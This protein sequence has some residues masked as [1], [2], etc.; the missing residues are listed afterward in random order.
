MGRSLKNISERVHIQHN[1]EFWVCALSYIIFWKFPKK[2]QN[3]FSKSTAGRTLLILSDY[4]FKIS[5][6][7]FNPL[8]PGGKKVYFSK[9]VS[10]S[11]TKIPG[12]FKHVCLFVATSITE[13]HWVLRNTTGWVFQWL[14]LP[15]HVTSTA[16]FLSPWF[17]YLPKFVH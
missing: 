9:Y 17:V 5:R 15:I 13:H 1:Y 10:K 6:T 11:S 7:H 12:L 16:F 3:R 4:S 14:L 2:I 8:V